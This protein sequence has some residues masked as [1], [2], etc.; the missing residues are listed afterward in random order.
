MLSD[1][2]DPY[3]FVSPSAYDTAWL[4]MI[5]ADS[6]SQPC[7]APMFKDC[8]DWVLN[9]QTE[10]GYWG[11]RDAHGN[12]TIESLPATLACLIALK[13][14]NVG[15]ENV[16]RANRP[17]Q[18]MNGTAVARANVKHVETTLFTFGVQ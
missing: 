16:E 10:E 1:Y 9:N 7:S 11:E 8:L 17:A 4:A 5:P 18:T 14:W 12:P 6:N 15:I 3:S 2:I 13:K